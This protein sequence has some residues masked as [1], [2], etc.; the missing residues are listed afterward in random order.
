MENKLPW[1]SVIT[2]VYNTE[3]YVERCFDSIFN[4][5]YKNIEFIIV[6]NASKGNINEIV[7]KY[8][9]IYPDFKIKLVELKENVGLF[10]GRLKGAEVA[11]GDYI[12]FIDSDD[13]VSI[14]FY[15]TLLDKAIETSADMVAADFVYEDEDGNLTQD[16][17]NPVKNYEFE[18][19]ENDIFD[20]F[21][22][23]KAYS[24]YFNLVWNK[25]YSIKLWNKCKCYFDLNKNK[26]V[27]CDD[28]IYS[29][30]FYKFSS[31]LVNVSDVK[32]Y[33]FKHKNANSNANNDLK[34]FESIL[35]DIINVFRFCEDFLAQINCK[36]K[37]EIFFWKSRY[38]R[39]WRDAI[40]VSKLKKV[41]KKYLI[42]YYRRGLGLENKE[43]IEK[44]DTDYFFITEKEEFNDALEV[45]R[46][47]IVNP[48]IKYISFDIFDTLILRNV[49]EPYDLFKFLN[50]K[51]NEIFCSN[52]YLS[53]SDIRSYCEHKAR[54]RARLNN[55]VEIT[56]D[57][58]YNE[59]RIR[60]GFEESIL[61]K[62][63]KYELE[64]ELNLCEKRKTVFNLY[65]MA[66]SVGK[67]I[68]CISDMYLPLNFIELLLK[69]NDY[70]K[71]E[72]IYL[73]SNIGICKNTSELFKYV[74]NDLHLNKKHLL[75][76][77]DNLNSDIKQANKIGIETVYIQ[78]TIDAFM[79]LSDNK[80]LKENFVKLFHNSTEITHNLTIFSNIGSR[81]LM[82]VIANKLMD[83]PYVSEKRNMFSKNPYF[84]GFFVLGLYIY[85]ISNWLLKECKKY[86]Y[87]KV[88]FM[89]RDGFLIKKAFD[90]LNEENIMSNYFYSSR[91]ALLP[92]L[93]KNKDD[94]LGLSF[95]IYPLDYSPKKVVSIF[96]ECLIF[97]E[98][99][100]NKKIL[101][102]GFILEQY[103]S[104]K[105]DFDEF[106]LYFARELFSYVK[107]NK[108]RNK[109]KSLLKNIIEENNCTFD[110]G[111]SGRSE[112]IF[113]SI[114]E[115]PVDAFYL[116]KNYDKSIIN[117]KKYGFNIRTL[118]N[119]FPSIDNE[120][121]LELIISD[122]GNSLKKYI[123]END[124]LKY[125][126]DDNKQDFITVYMINIMHRG[127]ID[128]V[129]KINH[130]FR[131]LH[132]E[133]YFNYIDLSYPLEMW[134]KKTDINELSFLKYAL[135]DDVL[136]K[137]IKQ[138]VLTNRNRIQIQE[139][140]YTFLN[141]IQKFII[142][143]IIDRGTLK[144]KV[145][146]KL[147]NHLILTYLAK[148]SY[149][150]A[151]TVYRF[152]RNKK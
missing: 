8:R 141:K 71:I 67:K 54:E 62:I 150:V 5:T 111:Y 99:I 81:C 78:R 113:A 89:S 101:E 16:V 37:K 50:I 23:Q 24:F 131:G 114:L 137:N 20:N 28:I 45:I 146:E 129:Y 61:N 109:F 105:E 140:R 123:M 27:M 116:Y 30:V 3:K 87:K 41:E 17:Y 122:T 56:L 59:I 106:I 40:Q 115:Y 128:F 73:S 112:S 79:F 90:I 34:K 126:F 19:N 142:L 93:I 66:I 22:E 96:K 36:K 134:M 82:A 42:K 132:E 138:E 47:K 2:T 43:I 125:F 133:L 10:H 98:D 80:T 88:H 53:F 14:D 7:S 118:F 120:I 52:T 69:K 12:A 6:N 92:F 77:G 139:N 25:I 74:L 100:T 95:Y 44:N 51:F 152:W 108:Y 97:D 21:I 55:K 35:N 63:K 29:F 65:K 70:K 121:F 68:I 9:Y 46:K 136:D 4:Q 104:S 117:S 11:T 76:I 86:R 151:R 145:K 49:W 13:R 119:Y 83:N 148:Y 48:E 64:L 135:F 75:H 84:I 102:K 85:G 58:I 130:L 103:F 33:Y 26:V 32:Y 1:I 94:F 144:F 91:K 147:K 107:N 39:M 31:K 18:L 124:K 127:A 149:R 143:S 72:K 38:F 110:I 60:Y 15:R 57:D